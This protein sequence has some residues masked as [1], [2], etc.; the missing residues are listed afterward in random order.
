MDTE[1]GQLVG[2]LPGA[3][4]VPSDHR[5]RRAVGDERARRRQAHPAGA[6]E[7][8]IALITNSEVHDREHGTP[9]AGLSEL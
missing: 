2:R 4:G 9:R 8:D 3:R 1:R 7:H 5:H 6:T